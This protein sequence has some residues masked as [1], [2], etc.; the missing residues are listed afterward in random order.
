[1]ETE[2]LMSEEAR[3][4]RRVQLG[5]RHLNKLIPEW[6]RLITPPKLNMNFCEDCLLGQ[7]FGDFNNVEN[8]ISTLSANDVRWGFA[9]PAQLTE[10]DEHAYY[11]TLTAAWLD[12]L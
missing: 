8:K 1:M 5:V 9:A 2:T 3:I 4:P 10:E 7:I 12:E 11:S 6:R